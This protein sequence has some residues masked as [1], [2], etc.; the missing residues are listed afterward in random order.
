MTEDLR[1][2]LDETDW[3]ILSELQKDA[4]ISYA[5]LGRLVHL[6]RPAAAER[7]HRLEMLG[8]I[9]GYRAEIDLS[10]LGY[11]ITAF[12]RITSHGTSAN[13]LDVARSTPEVLECHR[14][15][16]A[17]SFILK[18]VVPSLWKLEHVVDRFVRFGQ[19]TASVVMSSVMSKRIVTEGMESRS[20]FEDGAGI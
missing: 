17:D 13:L 8:V 20:G 19:V 2:K 4:R 15:T 3:L 5:E 1:S 12:L 11:G 18:V 7:I 10:S 14:G 16:G 9:S 6:S